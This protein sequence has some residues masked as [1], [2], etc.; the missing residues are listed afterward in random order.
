AWGWISDVKITGNTRVRTDAGRTPNEFIRVMLSKRVIVEH[1]IGGQAI[2]GITIAASQ[3][4]IVSRNH[5]RDTAQYGVRADNSS[6]VD[7]FPASNVHV[8]NNSIIDAGTH[9]I[10]VNATL[11][12]EIISNK[13]INPCRLASATGILFSGSDAGL[14]SSNS[15]AADS[16]PFAI[17]GVGG[18]GSTNT[19]VTLDNRIEGVTTRLAALTGTG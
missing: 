5:I 4:V 18:S 13:V 1:N 8:E 9:G 19:R 3:D 11:G 14:V 17:T 7:V 15:V 16:L 2:H 12:F 10:G 6:S